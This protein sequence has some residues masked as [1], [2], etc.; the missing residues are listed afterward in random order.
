MWRVSAGVLGLL[1]G[2]RLF[3]R[4]HEAEYTGTFD[5]RDGLVLRFEMVVAQDEVWLSR[6][7]K[8]CAHS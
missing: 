5:P 8:P 7:Q 4:A 1:V 3:D 2:L 6:D